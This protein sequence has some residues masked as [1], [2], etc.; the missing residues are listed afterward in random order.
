MR[1]QYPI[2]T[3]LL[4][5]SPGRG[6]GHYVLSLGKTLYSNND[7]LYQGLFMCIGELLGQPDRMPGSN[8]L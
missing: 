5:S 7:S 6:A 8:L 1:F 4:A 3:F 2:Q